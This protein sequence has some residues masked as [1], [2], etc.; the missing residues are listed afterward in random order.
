[1]DCLPTDL[2]LLFLRFSRLL[3]HAIGVNAISLAHRPRQRLQIDCISVGLDNVL[4]NGKA[5]HSADK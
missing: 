3:N 2:V 5:L 1:M 4:G